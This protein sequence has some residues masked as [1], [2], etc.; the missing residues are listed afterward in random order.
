MSH[1]IPKMFIR[2]YTCEEVSSPCILVVPALPV[3]GQAMGS[4]EN[5]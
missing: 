5:N 3:D 4:H 2:S 1:I